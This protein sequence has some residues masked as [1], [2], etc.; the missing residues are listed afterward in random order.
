MLTEPLNGTQR[1]S[2]PAASTARSIDTRSL[3]IVN[4]R[5]G[6]AGAAVPDRAARGATENTPLTGYPGVSPAT[7]LI[8]TPP[9]ASASSLLEDEDPGPTTRLDAETEGCER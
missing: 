3:A 8:Q 4:S 7:S 5:R 9:S 1:G 6:S 2:A